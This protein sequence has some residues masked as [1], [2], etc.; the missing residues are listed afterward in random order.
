MISTLDDLVDCVGCVA[1][2]SEACVQSLTVPSFVDYPL[3]CTAAGDTDLDGVL[4]FFDNCP[5]EPNPGQEDGDGDG[6]GDL[7]DP[8]P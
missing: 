6:V 3:D 7:C 2:F 4:D 5:F 1:T 8:T